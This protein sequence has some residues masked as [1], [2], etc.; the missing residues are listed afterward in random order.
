M[1]GPD[2]QD[3]ERYQIRLESQHGTHDTPE[4]DCPRCEAEEPTCDHPKWQQIGPDDWRC[5][6]CGWLDVA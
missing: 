3:E 6:E 5:V 1:M 2:E 4:P